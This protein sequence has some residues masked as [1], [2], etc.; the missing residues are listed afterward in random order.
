[1]NS[2]GLTF[3]TSA[4]TVTIV[5]VIPSWTPAR[6]ATDTVNAHGQRELGLDD[7]PAPPDEFKSLLHRGNVTFLI[8]GQRPSVANPSRPTRD[9]QRR[10]DAETRY[11]MSFTYKSRCRWAWADTS[12][13]QRLAI[14]VRYDKIELNTEH[15]IWLRQMPNR[16]TFWESPLVRHE[17]DHLRLSSDPRLTTRFV[18]AVK[19][20]GRIELTRDQTT[21]LLD[22]AK[23]RYE[24]QGRRYRSILDVLDS[25][26]AQQWV[27]EQLQ[28]E[29][30][31]TVELVEIRYQELDQITDHGRHPVPEDG[32]LSQLLAPREEP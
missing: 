22:S 5:T 2:H 17:L 28:A 31:R 9:V 16:D 29:F 24:T 8:G 14:G 18:T 1:M 10:F 13:S 27:D 7:L 23:K 12:R 30:D 3:L 4:L 11:H 26:D 32:P 25:D 19:K 21:L 15:Q 6:G 20:R